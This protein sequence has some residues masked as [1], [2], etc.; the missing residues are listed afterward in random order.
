MQAGSIC[1][2]SRD[3]FQKIFQTRVCL[4]PRPSAINMT[5]PAFEAER[6]RLLSIDIS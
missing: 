1:M 5:L 4:Q 6:R 3:V 2:E